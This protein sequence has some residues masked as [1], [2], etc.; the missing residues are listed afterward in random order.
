M[1]A[2]LITILIP[3][4]NRIELLKKAYHSCKNQTNTNF[5]LIIVDNASNDGSQD[6]LSSAFAQDKIISELIL[7]PINLGATF[8]ITNALKKVKTPWVTIVCDDDTIEPDFI[9]KSLPIISKTKT[10]FI[11]TGFNIINEY[12]ELQFTYSM[13]QQVLNRNDL[14]INFLNGNIQTAGVSGFFFLHEAISEPKNYP[15]GFL[16]DTMMCVEAGI[17]NG[18]EIISDCL[19]NRLVWSGGESSFSVENTKNYLESLLLFGKDL[20]NLLNNNQL[21]AVTY[22]S[23]NRTQSLKHFFRIII[24]PILAK[25]FLTIKDIKDFHTIINNNN[26]KYLLHFIF[27]IILYPFMNI[28]TLNIRQKLFKLL[29]QYRKNTHA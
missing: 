1:H 25:S 16:S 27:L 26:K 22:N 2:H 18:A 23:I 12:G 5:N 14:L 3:T 17:Y 21:S 28:N 8:S 24:F 9:E 29:R 19:Y 20:D 10:G 7:N 11:I 13:K 4:Y 6:F 15:K